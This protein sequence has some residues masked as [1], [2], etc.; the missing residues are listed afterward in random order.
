[1]ATTRREILL[2]TGMLAGT[3][4]AQVR[5]KSLPVAAQGV[6]TVPGT[7]EEALSIWDLKAMARERLPLAAWTNIVGAS[8]DEITMNWNRQ[9]YDE[10][11]LRPRVMVDP[12]QIDMTTTL[13]GETLNVPILLAPT[14]GHRG[15]H[16]GG[17]LATVRGA[18]KAGV[19]MVVS[20]VSSTP[21][22][23]I[24]AMATEPLWF[25]LYVLRDRSLTKDLVQRA[26]SAGCKALCVTVDTATTGPRNR[27]D[28]GNFRGIPAAGRGMPHLQGM[29]RPDVIESDI[30]SSARDPNVTWKD[31]DWLRSITKMPLVLKGVLDPLDAEQA[32]DEGVDGIIVSNHGGRNL[33]TAQATIVALPE[34]V[35]RVEGRIPI[36]ID[37]GVR[38]GTD[39]LKAIALGA[40][41]VLIGRPYRYGLAAGGAIGVARTIDILKREF[42]MAMANTGRMSIKEIDRSVLW[43]NY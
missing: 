13:F 4:M 1:M 16:P 42:E 35:D 37:G 31:V 6:E 25:Q 43:G 7:V 8:A 38:R 29:K 17:E 23:E 36:L 33:D 14:G 3:S 20:T 10:I 5:A 2:S 28:R 22:E 40:R 32:V 15:T 12:R 21:V 11:R 39:V 18:G 26:E 24:K 30:F 19:I 9:S 27:Q 34:I 41:A